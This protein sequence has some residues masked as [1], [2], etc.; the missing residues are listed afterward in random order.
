VQET[1]TS[2]ANSSMVVDGENLDKSDRE[3]EAE[4]KQVRYNSFHPLQSA[5]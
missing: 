1:R 3:Q 2:K 4:P 5:R